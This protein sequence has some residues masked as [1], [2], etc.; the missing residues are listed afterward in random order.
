MAGGNLNETSSNIVIE[1]DD[2]GVK[3]NFDDA[4][5]FNS[6]SKNPINI[7]SGVRFKQLNKPRN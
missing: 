2:E 7:K 4:R 1:N 6:N 3:S 5:K